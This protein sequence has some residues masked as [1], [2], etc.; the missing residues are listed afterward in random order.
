MARPSR[1][2]EILDAAAKQFHEKGFAATSLEDIARQVGMYKGSLYHYIKSKDDLLVAVVRE[3]SESILA[4]VREL[5]SLDLPPS[6]KIRRITRSHV[7]VLEENFTYCSV[8]LDEV[9]G[10][11]RSDEWSAIDREYVQAV[12]AVIQEGQQRRSCGRQLDSRT[13]TLALIGSLNWL[14]HWYVP[15]GEPNGA[16]IA[17]RFCDIFLVGIFSRASS[18]GSGGANAPRGARRLKHHLELSRAAGGCRTPRVVGMSDDACPRASATSA[19]QRCGWDT[20]YVP[21]PR[22]STEDVIRPRSGQSLSLWASQASGID[23][24]ITNVAITLTSGTL[25]GRLMLAKI[26]CGSVW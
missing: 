12:M 25:F 9:A 10:R 22:R 13:T 7:R 2:S 4:D 15:E 16:E 11:H 24:T 23:T 20:F 1:W 18:A 3:P 21:S 17:D 14:T 8:Y 6:E 26:H 19:R 5:S